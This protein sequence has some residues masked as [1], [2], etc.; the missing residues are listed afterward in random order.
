M[1]VRTEPGRQDDLLDRDL[2]IEHHVIG[3][4]YRAHAATA[5]HRVQPVPVGEQMTFTH[6]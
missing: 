1:L 2:T 3:T 4:P 6:S 5:D